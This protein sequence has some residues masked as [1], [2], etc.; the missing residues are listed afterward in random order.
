MPLFAV[1]VAV[2]LASPP[3]ASVVQA[4]ILARAL[5]PTGDL[6]RD[7]LCQLESTCVGS[8]AGVCPALS[9]K[10]RFSAKRERVIRACL[11]R[12]RSC[13]KLVLAPGGTCS[14]RSCERLG[15]QP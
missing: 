2:A 15:T 5:T 4:D 9:P 13:R 6:R 3:P 11:T 12:Y 10:R 8:A 1:L 7:A 14:A